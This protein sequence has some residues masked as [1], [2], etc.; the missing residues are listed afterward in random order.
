ME[1]ILLR[2][3]IKKDAIIVNLVKRGV[4]PLSVRHGAIEMVA[5]SIIVGLLMHV[6]IFSNYL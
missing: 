4:S 1:T 2:Q 3:K 5:I 6:C